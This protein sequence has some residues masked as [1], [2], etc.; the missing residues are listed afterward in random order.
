MQRIKKSIVWLLLMV[1]VGSLFPTGLTQQALAASNDLTSTTYF[2]PDILDIRKTSN[3][4]LTKEN[5]RD[6]VYITNSPTISISGTYSKVSGDTLRAQVDLFTW[7]ASKNSWVADKVH[8]A[9]GTVQKDTNT[10]ESRFNA[11]NLTLFPGLNRITFTG[12]IGNLEGS[13]S[14]YVLYDKIPYVS[15]LVISGGG[16]LSDVNLNEGTR[17]VVENSPISLLGEVHNTTKATVSVNGGTSLSTEIYNNQ[18]ATPPLNLSPGLNKLKIVFTN[19]SDSITITRDVYYFKLSDPFTDMYVMDGNQEY[20]VFESKPTLTTTGLSSASMIIQVLLPYSASTKDFATD[21]KITVNGNAVSIDSILDSNLYDDSGKFVPKAGTEVVING[22]LGN[23]SY[24][25]VTFK[26]SPFPLEK[27]DAGIVKTSQSPKVIVNYGANGSAWNFT[28]SYTPIFQYL[29]GQVLI[30]DL[31]YLPDYKDS[32]NG[33]LKDVSQTKLDGSQVSSGDFYIMVRTNGAPV[34]ALTGEYLPLGTKTLNISGPTVVQGET[35]A[36]IYKITGFSNGE[37]QVRFKYSNSSAATVN[38][39]YVSKNYIYV[40]N[41]FDGQT[42]TFNSKN[43][44][45]EMN[46]TGEYI[47]FENLTNAQYFINGISGDKLTQGVGADGS[48]TKLDVDLTATPKVTKFSLTLNIKPDGPLVYGENSIVFTGTSMDNAGN[49]REV[50]KE[51]RIY[52]VDENVSNISQFHPA[53]VPSTGK[54]RAP[55]PSENQFDSTDADIKELVKDMIA[56]IFEQPTEFTFKDD[57]YATS[58]QEYDLVI[59]GGGARNVN[60][61][62]GSDKIFTAS[63]D[64]T[65]KHEISTYQGYDYDLTGNENDFILRIRNFKFNAPG[66]HVYNLELI[67]STGA[68]TNQRLE[69]TRELA[70]YRLLA[71][72]PTVGDKYVVN[73]NFIRFDIEAEGATKVIIDKNEATRRP[74]PEMKDRF[75]YDYVG[76]KPDKTTKIKIQIVRGNSTINDTIEVYY[77]GAIEIDS[78]Y[79]AEKVSNKYS[80]FNKSLELS[81]PKGTVLQSATMNSNRVTKFYPDNKILFGIADPKDGV[82][83]RRNDYGGFI[84]KNDGI[85]NIIIPDTYISRFNSTADT[86][87]FTRISQ[88]YWINGGVGE[89]GDKGNLGYKPAT[90]GLAPYSTEGFFTAFENERKIVPSQRGTLTLSYDPNVVDQ[91]G[92]LVT[93]F[94]YIDAGGYGRWERIP[95][96][97]NSSKHTITVPFD[98][99]GYYTVMKLNRGYSDITNHPWARNILNAL[100]SKGIMEALRADMF[101]ADD[102]TTRGEFAT[103]LVKG[104]NLPINADENQQTFFDVPYGSKTATWDFEHLETAARAGIITGRTEGFFSPNMPI[105]R[106]DAAVMIARAMKSLKLPANDQKLKASLAKSFLDSGKMDYYALPAISAVTSAKIMSGTPVTLP[107]AKK[108]S[109]NFNPDSNMTR[110][111]AGK[112]AVELLKKTTSLFPKNFS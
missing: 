50:R 18:L 83:E 56:L 91:A 34:G 51:L 81:F 109:Y 98:Q 10:P 33:N 68:R 43:G 44:T 103:L 7:D 96:E 28:A 2:S 42:Y 1:L 45:N 82:V 100:Y 8:S 15:K 5:L 22:S 75:T 29:E 54:T 99:F 88:I 77:T 11:S 40:S 59:R 65:T 111:E 26:T 87:N 73:K 70:P 90:N 85:N 72:Q 102:Q 46:I 74:E 21:S 78:Q 6:E 3:L 84:N 93:V 47:G 86:S 69:I 25:L 104:L 71:P 16:L 31:M 57:K 12:T 64:N 19:A 106:Q 58:E 24:R 89:L 36:W 92:T 67:N 14:F 20:K 112:I 79:M 105:T 76:L 80:I 9:P 97:V 32:Y 66:T 41:L 55:F 101:G 52:I 49:K 17:V 39:S 95:G 53:K 60:L 94:R 13:E 63:L 108:P 23:P 38:I 27:D 62:F 30:K 35:N 110:A 48:D 4:D 37:Q 61:Y 107:G